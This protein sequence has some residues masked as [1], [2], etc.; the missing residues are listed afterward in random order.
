MTN[1]LHKDIVV[2]QPMPYFF[3]NDLVDEDKVFLAQNANNL[4]MA[5][6]IAVNWQR[7]GYNSGA[8]TDIKMKKYAFTL[9][10]YVNQ[11]SIT[12]QQVTG[13]ETEKRIRILGY[14]LGGASFFTTLLE[15]E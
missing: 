6:S 10:S 13:K 11:D 8:D 7:S 9:Y 3:K 4:D 5:I 2:G 14:K 1:Q 12:S 15:L